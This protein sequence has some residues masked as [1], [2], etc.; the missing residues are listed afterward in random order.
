MKTAR[1][2][3]GFQTQTIRDGRGPL[4][5]RRGALSGDPLPHR[6]AGQLVA[7]SGLFHFHFCLPDAAALPTF[8][9]MENC[10]AIRLFAQH[11]G[12]RHA[13]NDSLDHVQWREHQDKI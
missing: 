7:A 1:T 8:F 11:K 12:A 5:P 3:P 10:R 2:A 13:D 6:I 4:L 9:K